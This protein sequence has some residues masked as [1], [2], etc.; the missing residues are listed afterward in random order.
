MRR[1]LFLQ[2]SCVG[3]LSALTGFNVCAQSQDY[4]SLNAGSPSYQI[5]NPDEQHSSYDA[6]GLHASIDFLTDAE[7]FDGGV[8]GLLFESAEDADRHV[9]VGV[10]DLGYVIRPS[11]G[12]G[13]SAYFGLPFDTAYGIDV[14]LVDGV[15]SAALREDDLVRRIGSA[16]FPV[17]DVNVYVFSQGDALSRKLKYL[18]LDGPDVSGEFSPVRDWALHESLRG[19]GR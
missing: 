12:G 17:D 14:S 1:R 6:A 4:L 3:S 7:G 13:S 11:E 9:L 18:S 2:A 19:E 10:S 15:L 8:A 16:R 5:L